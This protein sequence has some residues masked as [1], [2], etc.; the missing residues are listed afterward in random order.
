MLV[1]L[2]LI[3]AV[4]AEDRVLVFER[5]GS[6]TVWVARA[7]GS[8][9]RKLCSGSAPALSP[10]ATWV[11]FEQGGQRQLMVIPV[12]GGKPQPIPGAAGATWPAWS[13]D[14]TR[15]LYVN[16][17]D[18]GVEV[19]KLDGTGHVLLAKDSYPAGW[20]PDGQSLYLHDFETLK[21]VQLN[22]TVVRS[23]ELAKLL[24][25][26]W[27]DSSCRLPVRDGRL[28]LDARQG[29]EP[30][31]QSAIWVV[32][33]NAATARR[34]VSGVEPSWEDAETIVYADGERIFR[35]RI[36]RQGRTLVVKGGT[37]PSLSPGR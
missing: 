31:V 11:A 33:L 2:L 5:N 26:W 1:L 25:G 28:L 27:L 6:T 30:K 22:G 4:G 3:T 23:W 29:E 32:D 16:L 9:A 10:D 14:G 13:P 12:T 7:D 15:L 37:Y 8:Q 20:G 21:E 18:N 35:H 17:R 34:E 24:P 19:R 36:G